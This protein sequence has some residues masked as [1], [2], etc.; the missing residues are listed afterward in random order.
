[1]KEIKSTSIQPNVKEILSFAT[2]KKNVEKEYELYMQSPVR[3]L[4]VYDF[5]CWLYW[6]RIFK[7]K[8]L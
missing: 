2:S 3:E 6:N 4:Y 1:M 7:S 8:A 5:E